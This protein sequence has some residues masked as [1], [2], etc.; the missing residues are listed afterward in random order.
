MDARADSSRPSPRAAAPYAIGKQS[1]GWALLGASRNA[2]PRFLAALRGLPPAGDGAVR[3]WPSAIYSHN[4]RQ[5][6]DFAQEH[7]LA[8][9][10]VELEVILA[11]PE[12]HCVYVAGHPRHHAEYVATALSAGKHVLCEPPLALSVSAA[13]RLQR[14]AKR[15]G[16]IL[17]LNYQQRFDPGLL[18]LRHW[19]L[20]HALGDLV[21][22]AVRNGTLLPVAQQG[23]RVEAAWGGIALDRTLRSVDAVRFLTGEAPR[24]AGAA[25]GPVAF[26]RGAARA[27]R[28]AAAVE[29]LHGLLALPRS[30][31]V[32]SIFD[33]YL[34]SHVPP[35]IEV[36]GATGSAALDPWQCH[37]SS[38]VYFN[39]HG[40]QLS[41]ASETPAADLWAAAVSAFVAAVATNGA[42]PISASEDIANL[43]LG[44]A[45]LA[46]AGGPTPE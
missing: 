14:L 20:E 2:A 23:W 28:D 26:G 7:A 40:E 41:A 34:I 38:A 16:R 6:R 25:A 17:G 1:Q 31:A 43:T 8:F 29:A 18:L 19:L 9:A 46:Q 15:N 35:R 33:A 39:R 32:F 22:G 37:S 45:L 13:Q 10:S 21:G 4:A 24:A 11:R 36:Y 42:P 30:G 44:L 12:V 27:E 3:A 5:A